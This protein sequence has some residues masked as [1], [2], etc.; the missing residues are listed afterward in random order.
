MV[1][2]NPQLSQILKIIN[3]GSNVNGSNFK[4]ASQNIISVTCLFMSLVHRTICAVVWETFIS[5]S[6]ILRTGDVKLLIWCCI[7]GL[8][9]RFLD[10]QVATYSDSVFLITESQP[11]V[12]TSYD[13]TIKITFSH[14]SRTQI[15]QSWNVFTY[16]D[17]INTL[18]R[19]VSRIF[20]I[21]VALKRINIALGVVYS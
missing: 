13:F 18:A 2:E 8:F 17:L 19:R 1:S 21:G 7:I 12:N 14:R 4:T 16:F 3:G 11:T 9:L 6:G 10:P 20:L 5:S 15:S